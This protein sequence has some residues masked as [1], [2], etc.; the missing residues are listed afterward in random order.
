MHVAGLGTSGD[1]V[2]LPWE[3][4]DRRWELSRSDVSPGS[5][6][7]LVTPWT[8][9]TSSSLTIT[10][11]ALSTTAHALAISV[12]LGDTRVEAATV[13]MRRSSG[14]LGL[15]SPMT[16][17]SVEAMAMVRTMKNIATA[18]Q[19]PEQLPLR[20]LEKFAKPWEAG[21]L[22]PAL[23]ELSVL[24]LLWRVPDSCFNWVELLQGVKLQHVRRSFPSQSEFIIRVLKEGTNLVLFR[25]V[26]KVQVCPQLQPNL[27]LVNFH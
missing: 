15:F 26:L 5:W 27:A 1:P 19:L 23:T 6:W 18:R 16:N 24:R 4:I 14:K 9:W 13:V 20:S 10:I 12:W 25:L 21:S 22:P 3:I 8:S 2:A 7:P 17:A 11:P